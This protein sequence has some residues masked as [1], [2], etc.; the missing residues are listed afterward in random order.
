MSDEPVQ[1]DSS[2]AANLSDAAPLPEPQA[3]AF[4]QPAAGSDSSPTQPS[5]SANEGQQASSPV[6]DFPPPQEAQRAGPAR[7]PDS[8]GLVSANTLGQAELDALEAQLA[9][10]GALETPAG[11]GVNVAAAATADQA[12]AG[13][14]E[15]ARQGPVVM[16]AATVKVRPEE[17]MPFSVPELSS[18]PQPDLAAGIDVLDDVE[19]DVKV[20]LGRTNMYIE[21][22]LRLGVG[23]VVELD[24]LAG[25]PVDIY[26][27]GRLIAQGEVLVLNDNFCVRINN[28]VSPVPDTQ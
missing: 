2:D 18:E 22:V 20:E 26:V 7:S 4:G 11:A 1:P 27:N 24:K 6:P 25:D 16:G 5:P 12:C 8:D 23:S 17:A 21:D 15:S 14:G 3:S 13:T 10:Q 19:L 28:I 9:A